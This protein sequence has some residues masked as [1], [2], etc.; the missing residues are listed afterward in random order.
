MKFVIGIVVVLLIAI[1]GV[2]YFSNGV[3]GATVPSVALEEHEGGEVDLSSESGLKIINSWAT[4]C[5][6]CVEEVPD[7]VALQEEFQGVEVVLVNRGEDKGKVEEFLVSRRVGLEDLRFIQDDTDAFY[8]A[9]GGFSMP[10]TLFVKD[11]VVLFHKRGVMKLDEMREL[12]EK[13]INGT[14]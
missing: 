7:F 5:P 10:E 8:N 2:L 9:V 6:F 12:T 3:E 1:F 14:L 11:G 4:W 13:L